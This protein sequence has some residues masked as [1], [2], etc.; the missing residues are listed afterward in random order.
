VCVDQEDNAYFC[1]EMFFSKYKDCD[2]QDIIYLPELEM[3]APKGCE[4]VHL[5]YIDHSSYRLS[6]Y[7]YKYF[8]KAKTYTE[9][10]YGCA[11]Y[12][13][14]ENSIKSFQKFSKKLKEG[15]SFTFKG[16]QVVTVGFDDHDSDPMNTPIQLIVTKNGVEEQYYPCH[17]E[18]E[19]CPYLPG[20]N[21]DWQCLS[22]EGLKQTQYC[23]FETTSS[24]GKWHF[25]S[26]TS[27]PCR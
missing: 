4:V 2:T 7:F 13:K 26:W 16:N 19:T 20:H 15:Q 14:L 18:G 8:A 21:R 5:A 27:T 1:K 23:C 17:P 22:K 12:S 9:R 6:G 11:T 25:G 3:L 24:G 10:N